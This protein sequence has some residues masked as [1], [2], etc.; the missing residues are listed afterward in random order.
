MKILPFLIRYGIPC[1]W[2]I[3]CFMGLLMNI[4]LAKTMPIFKQKP[5]EGFP[6][7]PSARDAALVW[8]WKTE[9]ALRRARWKVQAYPRW[10]II[11]M[12]G[13]VFIFIVTNFHVSVG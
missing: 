5:V 9:P 12:V 8:F 13:A 6:S 1:F 3:F 4:R 2:T 10:A 11:F 7:D